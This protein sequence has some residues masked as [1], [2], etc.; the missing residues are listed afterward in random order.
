MASM[1]HDLRRNEFNYHFLVD[2]IAQVQMSELGEGTTQGRFTGHFVHATELSEGGALMQHFFE[3]TSAA[4]VE[5]CLC[6]KGTGYRLPIYLLSS[7]LA[8]LGL[9]DMLF[10]AHD[11][12][13]LGE[14]FEFASQLQACVLLKGG[15]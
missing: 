6:Q 11:L 7:S 13:H 3:S 2:K 10:D 1:H 8:P 5:K 12:K 4:Q 14:P 9:W 15:A